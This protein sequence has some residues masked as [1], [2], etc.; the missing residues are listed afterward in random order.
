MKKS[1]GI[2]IH[3]ENYLLMGHSSGND[4]FDIPKG[5]QKMGE[6]HYDTMIRE[7]YEEFN[8]DLT[9]FSNSIRY[10]GEFDYS[11]YKSLLLYELKVEY[12]QLTNNKLFINNE[13][14]NLKCY[15]YFTINN[16][17]MLE[18]DYFELIDK[19]TIPINSCRSF[20]NMIHNYKLL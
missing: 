16:S 5:V 11:I 15:S 7:T 17:R 13:V 20:S 2:L 9:V 19:R 6:D 1:S 10:L 12:L 4:F 8:I 3:D 14:F 18:M